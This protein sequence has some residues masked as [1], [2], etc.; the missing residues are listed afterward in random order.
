MSAHVF[1]VSA[2]KE[3]EKFTK[4]FEKCCNAAIRDTVKFAQTVI[5]HGRH[6]TC[7]AQA[8]LATCVS[9]WNQVWSREAC[10]LCNEILMKTSN[11]KMAAP[12]IL[13]NFDEIFLYLWKQPTSL[14]TIF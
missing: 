14:H 1:P 12:R 9:A 7:G 2:F 8:T 5:Q 11:G 3:A 6:A 13:S 4:K 10:K